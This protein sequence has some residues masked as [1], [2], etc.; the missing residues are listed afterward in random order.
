MAAEQSST[1]H[2]HG[3]E[4]DRASNV[5]HNIVRGVPSKDEPQ[6]GWDLSAADVFESIYGL[7]EGEISIFV[8]LLLRTVY[9]VLREDGALGQGHFLCQG[10]SIE[11]T[12]VFLFLFDSI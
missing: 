7:L 12:F 9:I 3:V 5:A 11:E 2:N 4:H 8:E 10:G 1:N 6:P